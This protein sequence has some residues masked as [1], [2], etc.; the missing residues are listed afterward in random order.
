M[1]NYKKVLGLPVL[2]LDE[3]KIFGRIDEVV[4]NLQNGYTVA[5]GFNESLKKNSISILQM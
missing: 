2:T 1:I 5:I 3:G 4:F